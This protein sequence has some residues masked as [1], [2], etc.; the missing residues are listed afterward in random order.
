MGAP[1]NKRTRSPSAALGSFSGQ[2]SA[3]NWY[4]YNWDQ[5]VPP[6][7]RLPNSVMVAGRALEV[8]NWDRW[9]LRY[10]WDQSHTRWL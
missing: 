5:W 6:G 3:T 2:W 1:S 10:T 4:Y 9:M 7:I 8:T